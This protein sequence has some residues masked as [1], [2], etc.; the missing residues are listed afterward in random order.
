[1]PAKASLGR[2]IHHSRDAQQ[3]IVMAPAFLLATYLKYRRRSIDFI[4]ARNLRINEAV[5][6]RQGEALGRSL[7]G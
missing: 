7:T 4:A 1:L 3:L 5:N 2:L 6:L